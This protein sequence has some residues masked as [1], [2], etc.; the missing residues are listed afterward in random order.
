MLNRRKFLGGCGAT[1]AFAGVPA[2]ART[3]F[4]QPGQSLKL[5]IE[6]VAVEL[7]PNMRIHTLGYNGTAPGPL[8]RVQEGVPLNVQVTNAT[9]HPELVHWHGLH[10][11][12]AVDGAEE[13]GTPMIPPRA[14]REYTF[15]PSPSGSRWYHT[16]T[17]A[18]DN[19]QRA[20]YTGQ[21]GFMYIDPKSE[22]GNYDHEVFLAV[23]HWEPSF[24]QM[25]DTWRNCPE[26][27]YRYASFNDK[28][29]G[30]GD[31]LR[32]RQGERV[33]FHFLNASA[34]E[35]VVLS[36]PRHTFT[37]TALDGN[38]VAS[39]VKVQVLS[40]GVAERI[41]AIVEMDEPGNWILGSVNDEERVKG[42]GVQVEYAGQSGAALWEPPT[43]FDWHYAL[44]SSGEPAPSEADEQI[45]MLFE[46]VAGRDG[47]RDTWTIN[48]RSF[49]QIPSLTV[50]NGGRYRIR[51]VNATGCDHPVHLHRHTF[52]LKRISEVPVS[53]IHKDTINLPR[54]GAADIELMA[55]HPGPTLFHC[56]QQLHMDFG[57]MQMIQ[58]A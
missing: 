8:L 28:M 18:G 3:L 49:P 6:P 53:G 21:F 52:E 57:F 48:G 4:E 37:V 24:E 34:T 46:K 19:L 54:Y 22:P 12:S 31:P 2:A 55:N 58:Y 25:K 27:S 43:A 45:T 40:L 29:L 35:N 44:F 51:F 9:D 17:M 30:A 7:G 26:I 32:V 10:I 36:L 50:R 5:T 56:H 42:L 13:E 47:E 33:L 16:H 41:D 20:T 11:P 38:P 39:P 23:H 1:A 14:S 15:I